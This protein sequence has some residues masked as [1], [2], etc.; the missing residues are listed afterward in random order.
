MAPWL[1]FNVGFVARRSPRRRRRPAA[2][3]VWS[4]W[5]SVWLLALVP[6]AVCSQLMVRGLGVPLATVVASLVAAGWQTTSWKRRALARCDQVVS[7]PLAVTAARRACLRLG[8]HL[9]GWCVVSDWALMLLMS[10]SSHHPV[11][12]VGLMGV[13]WYERFRLPH[14]DRRSRVT[15]LVVAGLGA[16]AASLAL[17][18]G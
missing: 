3:E 14:H 11:A 16:A 7:P 18:P 4:S 9:G 2:V 17:A 8:A 15:G 10:A 1:R 12:V 6:V 13:A 5:T